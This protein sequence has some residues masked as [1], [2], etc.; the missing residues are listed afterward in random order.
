MRG[1]DEFSETLTVALTKVSDLRYGENPHQKG[2]FYKLDS[3]KL[4]NQGFGSFVQHHGKDL[5]YVNL[6]DADA[7]FNLVN[8]YSDNAI[9]IIKH[10]NP[11]CLAVGNEELDV[12]FEKALTQG[13]AISAYGGII[14]TNKNIDMKFADKIRTLLS[15]INGIRM[16]YEIVVC[17]SIDQDALDHLK[18]KSKDLRIL[19]VPNVDSSYNWQTMR[20][21]RG[22]ML[23]QD[24][25]LSVEKEFELVSVRKP[26]KRE[27][28]DLTIAWIVCKHVKSNAITFVKDGVLVGMG[29]GQP[30][31]V[32]SAKISGEAAQNKAIGAAAASDALI[33]FPDTIEVCAEYGVT[34]LVHTGGSIRDAESVDIANKLN[35]SFFTSGVRHFS[36]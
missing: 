7:A 16:F 6:L 20:T 24:S 28:E 22:G 9:A 11:C 3:T 8:D 13:D 25:D 32:G 36:H 21:L 26:T 29:A 35:L 19:T 23:I 12:L 33:P 15:P 10:T 5:S 17:S 34:S 31:R 30:N 4:P 27:L 14:A 2:S 1:N 18:K